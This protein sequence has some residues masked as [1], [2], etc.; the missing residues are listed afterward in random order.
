MRPSLR[1]G[2]DTLGWHEL[3]GDAVLGPMTRA[4]PGGDGSLEFTLPGRVAGQHR[5]VLVADAECILDTGDDRWAGLIV[6]DSLS[7]FWAAQPTVTVAA[8]GMWSHAANRRDVDYAWEDSDTTQWMRRMQRWDSGSGEMVGLVDQGK[9]TVDTEGRLYIRADA[10]RTY[11]AG[12][13]ASLAYWLSRGLVDCGCRIVGVDIDYKA[14]LP[15]DWECRLRAGLG[16][17][18]EVA[19]TGALDWSDATTRAA[20]RAQAVDLSAPATA[21]VIN[22][23][24][25]GAAGSPATDP[26]WLIRTV[27]LHCRMTDGIAF[28]ATGGTVT[29]DGLYTVHK[30][31]ATDTLVCTGT[32]DAEVFG[33]AG[34]GGG[35]GG[36][37]GAGEVFSGTETLSGSML[38]TIGAGGAGK[39]LFTAPGDSGGDTTFGTRTAKGGGGGGQNSANGADGGSGGGG[40]FGAAVVTTGGAAT[41]AEQGNAGGSN[42]VAGYCG[43]GGGGAG[44]AGSD[45][46]SAVTGGAGGAGIDSDIVLR[47]SSVGYAGGGGGGDSDGVT[48]G[49]AT[50]GGGAGNAVS[51]TANTGGGGGAGNGNYSYTGG[52]G[53]SGIGVVRYLTPTVDRT[54][55]LSDAMGD[56]AQLTGLATET[57]IAAFGAAQPQL[58]LRAGEDRSVAD[59]ERELA[60]MHDDFLEY[61]YDRTATGWRFTANELPAA[62]D[63]TR[64]RHWVLDD[65]RAGEDT[66]GVV[67]DPEA[68]PDFVRV[69]YLS[70][71]VAG[72]PDGQPRSICYPAEPTSFTDQVMLNTDQA[73]VK[74][75]DAQAL[76]IAQRL[77]TQLNSA[78]FSG[79]AELPAT[80]LTVSGQELP[81]RL[82][83]PGDRVNILGRD[84]ATDLYISETSYD[85]A[86]GHMSATIGWPFDVITRIGQMPGPNRS[87]HRDV[88]R[89]RGV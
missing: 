48:G 77:H 72:I 82:M 58:A 12:S 9:F 51:A 33:V 47:G 13:T 20:W 3:G 67:R 64:N 37:G 88:V 27:T 85:W 61:F 53:G 43:G 14:N 44:A 87:G 74:L 32:I 52:N 68:S 31:T 40:G 76:A 70:S 46:P 24:N 65:A 45:A 38:F 10:D 81:S 17:P 35:S 42:A 18:W 56:L 80:L 30:F 69:A 83:R 6:G 89:R 66:S 84:G 71:G 5:N 28:S 54:V 79:T 16:S 15:T 78:A 19:S 29:T 49:T 36:G 57:R 41:G 26:Y 60:A 55:S 63:P 21:V 34:G 75:T 62:V 22:L 2:S 7:G 11:A 50:H 23:Y 59:G 4:M 25:N 73:G 86:T 1:V 39:D 8:A